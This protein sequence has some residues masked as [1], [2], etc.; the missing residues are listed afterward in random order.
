M[1]SQ[2]GLGIK[3]IAGNRVTCSLLTFYFQIVSTLGTVQL[4]D[5]YRTLWGAELMVKRIVRCPV[6]HI[7]GFNSH[8]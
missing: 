6:G 1:F 5:L 7:L 4:V 3:H 8:P 2:K